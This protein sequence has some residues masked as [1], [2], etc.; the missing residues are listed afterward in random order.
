MLA[1]VKVSSALSKNLTGLNVYAAQGDFTKPAC[2]YKR[3]MP[4]MRQGL[5]GC[6]VKTDKL[7]SIQI[8][9]P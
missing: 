4:A 7:N 2:F 5:Y 6:N 8:F 9:C 3:R 1:A